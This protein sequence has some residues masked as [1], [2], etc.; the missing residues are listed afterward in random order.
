MHVGDLYYV[1][2]VGAR[3]IGLRAM[4]IDPHDLYRGY[5][6]D[7][8]RTLGELAARLEAEPGGRERQAAPPAVP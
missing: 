3:N 6:A 1:D 7:R 5:D 2:V 8:V 4:L